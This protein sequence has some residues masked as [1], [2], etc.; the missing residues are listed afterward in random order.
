MSILIFFIIKC[1]FAIFFSSAT[2]ILNLFSYEYF[3]HFFDLN[4]EFRT[5]SRN[6]AE[7][8]LLIY[9]YEHAG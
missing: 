8:L 1:F 6:F 5:I 2:K 9:R 7:L 3:N 4:F